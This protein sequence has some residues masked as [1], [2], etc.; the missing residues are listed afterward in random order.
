MPTRKK[1]SAKKLT[2]KRS[3]RAKRHGTKK[4]T[5]TQQR[6]LAR[7]PKKD[8]KKLA[9]LAGL[10]QLAENAQRTPNV[11]IANELSRS[12]KVA[13]LV[14]QYGPT[15]GLVTVLAAGGLGLYAVKRSKK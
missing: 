11:T 15:T 3:T 8:L 13:K 10:N 7:L 4:L 6:G 14:K 2:R 9:L 1:K 12:A 5:P